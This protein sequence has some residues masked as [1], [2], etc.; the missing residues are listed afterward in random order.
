M[1][2]LKIMLPVL[3]VLIVFVTLHG[4][5]AD[6]ASDRISGGF[7]FALIGDIPRFGD[8]E[9]EPDL[10]QFKTL[11]KEINDADV[12]FIVHDGDF[13][14]GSS[15][16]SDSEFQRWSD[17]IKTFDAPFFFVNGDNEWVD[18]HRGDGNGYDPIERLSKLREMFYS[19]PSSLGK[20]KLAMT[21]QSDIPA[22]PEYK[23]YS[24]NF[25]WDYG[26][27]TFVGLNVQ[28][29]NNNLGRTA[30]MDAE[31]QARNEAVNAF[32][33]ESFAEAKKNDSLAIVVTI[34]ANPRFENPAKDP[35]KDGYFD[36]RAVLEEETIAF[37]PKPVILVHGDSHYFRIDKP[38]KGAKSKRRVEHFTR[39][40]TFGTPDVHWLLARVDYDNPSLFIFEQRIVQ[41]NLIDHR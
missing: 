13:K 18:C 8:K 21:R 12:H 38:M 23:D 28:G 27:I 41:E 36:F 29:S 2:I 34:Q 14:S 31:F 33:K 5:E 10:T 20:E 37:G 1:K 17:L 26:G 22:K 40:E 9:L 19:E 11:R 25:R 6:T 32:L 30:E 4:R 3:L 16:C 39:V 15:P 24:E 7:T 35:A